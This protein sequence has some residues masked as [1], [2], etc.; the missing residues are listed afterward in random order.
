MCIRDSSHPVDSEGMPVGLGASDAVVFSFYAT[1]T[2]TSGEGGMVVSANPDLVSRMRT[3][4]LLS[5]IHI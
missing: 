2:M 4:R 1:K 5:L 3:M